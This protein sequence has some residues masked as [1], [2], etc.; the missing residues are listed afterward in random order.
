[1]RIVAVPTGSAEAFVSAECPYTVDRP[2]MVHRW[3]TLTFLHWRFDP[4]AVQRLLPPGLTVETRDGA[5]WAGRCVLHAC[6]HAPVRLGA[7]AV[8][9]L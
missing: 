7:V 3:E 8:A 2:I 6:R 9:L 4:G 1:M 5:A